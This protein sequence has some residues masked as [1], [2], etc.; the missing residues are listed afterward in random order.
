MSSSG[1][2]LLSVQIILISVE[3]A[4]EP[5]EAKLLR[6]EEE[7]DVLVVGGG[8]AGVCAALASARNGAGTLL[9]EQYGFLFGMATAALVPHFNGVANPQGELVVKGILDEIVQRLEREGGG[10][11]YLTYPYWGVDVPYDTEILKMV[12][13]EM[14]QEEGVKILFHTFASDAI[15]HDDYVRGI[16]IQNKSGRSI[17]LAKRLIDCTGD[18]DVATAA[19]V[20]FKKG[21]EKDGLMMGTSFQFMLHNVDLEKVA[22]FVKGQPPSPIRFVTGVKLDQTKESY[23][24][25]VGD[26]PEEAKRDLDL[27]KDFDKFYLESIR[28]GM[29]IVG[30]P[31]V[32]GIDPTNA[33]DLTRAQIEGRRRVYLFAEV[34]RR[35]VPG[36]ERSYVAYIPPSIGIR[37]SRRIVGRY[38][39]TEEDVMSGR[40]FEDSVAR[41]AYPIDL[42]GLTEDMKFFER[43]EFIKAPYYHIPYRCMVPVNR[44]NLLVAGRSISADRSAFGSLRIMP[45][46]MALGQAAGT[47]A[48]LSLKSD[49][50][51]SKVD[52]KELRNTLK[53]QGALI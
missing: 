14:L 22:E 5:R 52:V 24:R 8:P 10:V 36:F 16:A 2:L 43:F 48:A 26:I 46:C 38:V 40:D 9:V 44:E 37:E 3:F 41:G 20:P 11:G 25:I 33:R 49:V 39:L 30:H 53:D 42:H 47:A 19:G 21:R 23:V 35:Y 13:L 1:K 12:A 18:A 51:I 27:P 4:T 6:I 32:V 34:L 15:V 45:V 31:H 50:D 17:I 29:A 28:D 7:V